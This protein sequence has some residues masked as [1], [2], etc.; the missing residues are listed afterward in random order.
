MALT[1][2]DMQSSQT[3]L[4]M[5]RGGSTCP[6]GGLAIRAD[7]YLYPC[8]YLRLVPSALYFLP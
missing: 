3:G 5:K 7:G 6:S 4:E 2:L 1:M 8:L